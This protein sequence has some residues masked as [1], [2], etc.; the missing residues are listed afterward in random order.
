MTA[1]KPVSEIMTPDPRYHAMVT[2]NETGEWLR[3]QLADHHAMVAEIEISATA[4]DEARTIF[5]RG[6][7]AFI[8]AWFDYELTPLAEQQAFAALEVALRHRL[9]RK[10]TL[11]L[12]LEKAVEQGLIPQ[13]LGEME[14]PFVVAS[15]RNLWAHG[16]TNFAGP[17]PTITVMRLCADLIRQLYP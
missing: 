5:D 7:H 14:L 8:Y 11:R 16:S 1:L 15:M 10:G 9:N 2:V 4:P 17:G 3:M 13:M 6:R 12:L